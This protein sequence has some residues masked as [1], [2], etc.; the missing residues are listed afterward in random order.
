MAIS[1][2]LASWAKVDV[3][4]LYETGM[5]R[6]GE[7]WR[8]VTSIFP[9]VDALH[10]IFNV[11]WLWVFGR[12]IEETYGHLKTA[13]LILLFGAGSGA[14]EFAFAAGGVGLSGVG[15][16]L[17]GLLWVLSR[18]D[19]RFAEALDNKTIQLFVF[20]FFFCIV[21]TVTK[22]MPVANIAHGAGALLGA[23]TGLAITQ[24]RQ[25]V[26]ACACVAGLI[27]FG[28]WGATAGRPRLNRSANA[29]YDEAR[30]GYEALQA[31]K[32]EEAVRW[33]RDAVAM[34]P[35]MYQA[36][37]DLGIAYQDMGN[38]AA[39]MDAYHQAAERG[40]PHAA[41]YLGTVYARGTEGVAKDGRQ[42]AYWYRK[43]A[44]A[45]DSWLLNNVAWEL[46]TSDDPAVRD[47]KSALEYAQKAVNEEKTPE[48]SH[49]D[50]LAAA[51]YANGRYE[52]AVKTQERAIELSKGE[53]EED[54]KSQDDKRMLE[55][56]EKY[57]KALK[58]QK[59]G[60][61]Q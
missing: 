51:F 16:G 29:G 48:A 39:A 13:G 59:T 35:G 4:L 5:I 1:V 33:F 44:E 24:P 58:S 54:E 47:P 9:H 8:L 31:H 14:L 6:R 18:H 34:Q 10:L 23:L 26:T 21:T 37:F 40:D 27:G 22:I 55:R 7:L 17:F 28:L 53:N 60:A 3:S 25:R 36:W 38:N 45:G 20:W 46:T 57:G 11:Y 61:R 2:T 15:Y 41:Y 52:E 56:L 12:L 42:A 32:N 19:E 50:T 30:W 49:M 43:A